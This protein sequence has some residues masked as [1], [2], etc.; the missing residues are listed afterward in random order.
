MLYNEMKDLIPEVYFGGEEIP[1]YFDIELNSTYSLENLVSTIRSI[2]TGGNSSGYID[3]EGVHFHL[4]DDETIRVDL[5]KRFVFVSQP[6]TI[7]AANP[8]EWQIFLFLQEPA[9]RA[10][11]IGSGY[12]TLVEKTEHTLRICKALDQL[13]AQHRFLETRIEM[14]ES[15]EAREKG[16]AHLMKT[17][18]EET[19]GSSTEMWEFWDTFG[20]LLMEQSLGLSVRTIH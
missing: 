8:S 6:A 19:L 9:S 16:L 7:D 20:A 15:G 10:L 17:Y 13:W 3:D 5:S 4:P 12:V 1:G 14:V 18:E 11:F 2:G